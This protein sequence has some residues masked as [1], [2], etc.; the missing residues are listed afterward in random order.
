MLKNSDTATAA[1]NIHRST[2][3]I[4]LTCANGAHSDV[5][6]N[7]CSGPIAEIARIEGR[8]IH[9]PKGVAAVKA[10]RRAQIYP[11]ELTPRLQCVRP[12]TGDF[13]D[14]RN[15]G[16]RGHG[17][18]GLGRSDFSRR[19]RQCFRGVKPKGPANGNAALGTGNADMELSPKGKI[20]RWVVVPEGPSS[21]RRVGEQ[22]TSTPP[23]A[24]GKTAGNGAREARGVKRRRFMQPNRDYSARIAR[25]GSH[26]EE[27]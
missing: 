16:M 15:F 25:P 9:A 8:S 24:P 14:V 18:S 6:V 12:H 22:P 3:F 11:T 10:L 5:S 20:T 27:R 2:D 23:S 19:P 13:E 4:G 1:R 7:V 21:R 17:R 26:F